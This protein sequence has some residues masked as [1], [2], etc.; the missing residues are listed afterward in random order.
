[1]LA[2]G[3][4]HSD[5]HIWDGYYEIGGGKKLMLAD[6]GIKLP[7]TMGHENVGEVVAVGPD[8]KDVKVGECAWSIRGWAAANARYAS[9]VMR[10]SASSRRTSACSHKAATRR[11][12]WCRATAICSTSAA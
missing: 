4:C 3:V 6:R 11:T 12:C 8:A 2:A 10:T 5:L 9:A 7:L 1:M